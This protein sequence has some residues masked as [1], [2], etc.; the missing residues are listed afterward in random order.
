M[1]AFD[2]KRFLLA[3]GVHTYA[4]GHHA[5]PTVVREPPLLP[6]EEEGTVLTAAE[7]HASRIPL[8]RRTFPPVGQDPGSC[9][10]EARRVY[11]ASAVVDHTHLPTSIVPPPDPEELLHFIL[12]EDTI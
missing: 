7:A 3:D 10:G 9:F 2:D 5:V 8:V 4:Y 12:N 11:G 1:C 6:A